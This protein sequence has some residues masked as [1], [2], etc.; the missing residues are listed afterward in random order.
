MISGLSLV[1]RVG[2]IWPGCWAGKVMK[3]GGFGVLMDRCHRLVGAS[4]AGWCSPLGILFQGVFDRLR[5]CGF[6][7]AVFSAG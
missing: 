5:P 3:G 7:G 2:L 6:V 4:S 1:D